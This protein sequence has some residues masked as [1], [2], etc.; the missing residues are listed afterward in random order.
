M[1]ANKVIVDRSQVLALLPENVTFDIAEDITSDVV[2]E[3]MEKGLPDRLSEVV[4]MFSD[5]H[6]QLYLERCERSMETRGNRFSALNI[7]T[8]EEYL[9]EID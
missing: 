9:V 4:E 6:A 2:L 5:K 3:I 8:E 1:Q 7:P